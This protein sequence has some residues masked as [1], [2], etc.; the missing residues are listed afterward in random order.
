MHGRENVSWNIPLSKRS[1][2]AKPLVKRE[3]NKCIEIYGRRTFPLDASS[4]SLPVLW[5]SPDQRAVLRAD[6]CASRTMMHVL[7]GGHYVLRYA[8]VG[9]VDSQCVRVAWPCGDECQWSAWQRQTETWP[10]FARKFCQPKRVSPSFSLY[11]R[12]IWS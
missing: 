10:Y 3:R 9:F 4:F 11:F 8:S 2:S 6:T 1:A 5:R 12:F 7:F